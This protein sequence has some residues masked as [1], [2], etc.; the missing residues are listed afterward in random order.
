MT[1]RARPELVMGHLQAYITKR[2]FGLIE[3][4]GEVAGNLQSSSASFR[5]VAR[6]TDLAAKITV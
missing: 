2:Q 1:G 4:T 5:C 6:Y 3:P